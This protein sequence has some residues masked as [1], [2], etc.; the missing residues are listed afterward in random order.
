MLRL[1]TSPGLRIRDSVPSLLPADS[2]DKSCIPS[3]SA[4]VQ[5]R[6]RRPWRSE[7]HTSELQSLM[8]IS[9]DVLCLKK[10]TTQNNYKSNTHHKQI[11]NDQTIQYPHYNLTI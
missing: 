5:I 2:T 3:G 8:R 1:A 11:P 7:E 4:S 10:K 6:I 9:Y